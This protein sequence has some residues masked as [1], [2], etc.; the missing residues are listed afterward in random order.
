MV[1]VILA[2]PRSLHKIMKSLSKAIPGVANACSG[3][4]W[5]AYVALDNFWESIL[6]RDYVVLSIQRGIAI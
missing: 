4:S 2:M 5:Q 1:Y 6:G 3:K